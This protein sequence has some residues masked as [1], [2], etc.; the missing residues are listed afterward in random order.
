[1]YFSGVHTKYKKRKIGKVPSTDW[2][3]GSDS[4]DF[5]IHIPT[6]VSTPYLSSNKSCHDPIL[7]PTSDVGLLVGQ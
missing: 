3:V 5:P 1:M 7:D 2:G 6:K 4:A